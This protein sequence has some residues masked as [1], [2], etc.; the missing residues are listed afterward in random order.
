MFLQTYL[1]FREPIFTPVDE[2]Q[3][4]DYV[5]TIAETGR[6]P[7]YGTARVHP[8]LLAV[9]LHEYPAPYDPSGFRLPSVVLMNYE[10][11]QFPAYYLAAAPLYRLLDRDARVA[12]YAL[13]MENVIFSAAL[14]VVLMVLL[15]LVFSL[16]PEVL[17]FAPLAFLLM[18]GVALR[19]S[20]VT[21]EVLAALLLAS[22][23]A[24]LLQKDR[25][26]PRWLAFA[27]GVLLGIAVMTKIT[28]VGA[29]PSVLAA[30]ATR[31]GGLRLRL[32]PGAVGFAITMLPWLAWSLAV[33]HSPLAWTT[34]HLDVTFCEC[35]PPS[36]IAVWIDF[37]KAA[38]VNFVL[39]WE[40]AGAEGACTPTCAGPILHTQLM[41]LGLVAV[42]VLTLAALVWVVFASRDRR[43]VAWRAAFLALLAI[44]GVA[45]GILGLDISLNRFWSTDLREVYVFAAPVVLLL[46]GLAAGFRPRWVVLVLGT[47]IIL[48][49]AIDYQ[50]Y[51]SPAGCVWCPPRQFK[52]PQS[53]VPDPALPV[54]S[55]GIPALRAEYRPS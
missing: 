4:T 9:Y 44:A 35:A 39:P 41:K 13:R 12:I 25:A 33:Y 55:G 23:F 37:I 17:A 1:V 38:W 45:A 32:V 14:L 15:R 26:S 36:T 40:W 50:M 34:T 49:V 46:G 7:I 20:Q 53:M 11:L 28:V 16:R 19:H 6:L 27:E 5:R 3:H 8:T 29:G 51:T 43:L 31:A 48:W 22:L 24:L 10:A 42:A 30:W 21:N 52:V 18:P 47:L 54:G 2:L